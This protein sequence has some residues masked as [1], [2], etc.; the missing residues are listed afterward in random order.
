MYAMHTKE[1]QIQVS[2]L[3]TEGDAACWNRPIYWQ[4]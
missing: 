1:K 4:D 3:Y 2:L